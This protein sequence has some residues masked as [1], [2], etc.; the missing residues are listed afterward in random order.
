MKWMIKAIKYQTVLSIIFVMVF[1]LALAPAV[2]AQ[3]SFGLSE[4]ATGLNSGGD[5][6]AT[7]QSLPETV[8]RIISVAF[9][10]LG[11]IAV[12][13]ILI[14]GFKWM[15]A[16]GA[17]EKT[18]DARNYIVSGVIGLAIILS[19]YAITSFVLGSLSTATGT[20]DTTGLTF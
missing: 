16:G 3:D 2:F 14:G 5:T 17:E 6:I 20:G 13:I 4:V 8:G 19:A 9:G 11:I 10:L 7:T 18:T 15:T 1:G 12:V